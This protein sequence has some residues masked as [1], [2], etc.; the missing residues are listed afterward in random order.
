LSAGLVWFGSTTKLSP[1]GFIG[2][3]VVLSIAWLGFAVLL[4]VAYARRTMAKAA[5]P[6]V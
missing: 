5:A 3:N 6:G 4:G 2:A 1:R